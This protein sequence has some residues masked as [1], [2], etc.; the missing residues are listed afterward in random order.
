MQIRF[1]VVAACSQMKREKEKKRWPLNHM[2]VRMISLRRRFI[3]LSV[4]D[5]KPTN[6]CR[7]PC[8][9]NWERRPFP[10]LRILSSG[11]AVRIHSVLRQIVKSS[12]WKC[13]AVSLNRKI[14]RSFYYHPP[15][16]RGNAVGRVCLC[17]CHALTFESF[18]LETS[19]LV[20]RYIFR[21]GQVHMSR[22]N[23]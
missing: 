9:W 5:I 19:F 17:V 4:G 8:S 3:R 7:Q 22:L 15:V 6:R 13:W 2:V 1:R 23:G 18:G 11:L 21:I 20:S 14:S 12:S 10:A 16:R